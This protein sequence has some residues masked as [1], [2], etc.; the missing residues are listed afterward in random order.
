MIR[1]NRLDFLIPGYTGY[2]PKNLQEEEN[3]PYEEVKEGHI[4]GYSGHI[5]KIK[6]ENLFGKP[7]GRITYEVHKNIQQNQETYLTMNQEKYVDQNKVQ[8]KP[9]FGVKCL[10]KTLE[11]KKNFRDTMKNTNCF[12]KEN[13]LPQNEEMEYHKRF[14]SKTIPGYSGHISGLYSENIFGSTFK[15]SQKKAEQE[16]LQLEENRNN[17][18]NTQINNIPRMFVDNC[19]NSIDDQ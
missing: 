1:S 6:S 5:E 18:F 10:S 11:I 12:D 16:V 7:Y 14:I 9:V 4:P 2:I 17:N 3:V 8:E 19:K 13:E 15:V